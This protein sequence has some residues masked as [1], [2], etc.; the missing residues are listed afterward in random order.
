MV[1]IYLYIYLQKIG[2][3]GE[4]S[5]NGNVH[6]VFIIRHDYISSS[7]SSPVSSVESESSGSMAASV[8]K[9][10]KVADGIRRDCVCHRS[11]DKNQITDAM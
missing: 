5:K 11:N 7:S 6:E 2:F 10:R 4:Q 8:T 1:Y 9:L 3:S